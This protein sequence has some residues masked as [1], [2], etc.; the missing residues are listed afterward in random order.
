MMRQL[1]MTALQT[2][3]NLIA[4]ANYQLAIIKK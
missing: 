1:L 4:I 3:K 2:Q